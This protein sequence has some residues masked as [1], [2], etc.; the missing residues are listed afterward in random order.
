MWFIWIIS[1]SFALEI[2]VVFF[3]KCYDIIII[4]IYNSRNKCCEKTPF[5]FF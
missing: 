2:K 3:N 5:L 1:V 4:C